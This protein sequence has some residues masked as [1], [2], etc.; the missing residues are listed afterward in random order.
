[1]ARRFEQVDYPSSG[2]NCKY[3]LVT[4][5]VSLIHPDIPKSVSPTKTATM[6]HA[7]VLEGIVEEEEGV[8]T[9]ADSPNDDP[10][11]SEALS[12]ADEINEMNSNGTGLTAQNAALLRKI[13]SILF[14][15]IRLPSFCKI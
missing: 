3:N 9:R 13:L 4:L 5:I 7:G 6:T 10:S 11:M 1:M 2:V 12:N 14:D 15:T 8:S